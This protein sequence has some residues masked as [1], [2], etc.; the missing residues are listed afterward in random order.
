MDCVR[1]LH[2][3]KPHE[4]SKNFILALTCKHSCIS[5]R[6]ITGPSRLS[7][8]TSLVSWAF[9]SATPHLRSC[10][11]AY[12]WSY[13]CSVLFSTPHLVK[14]GLPGIKQSKLLFP[15]THPSVAAGF[16]AKPSPQRQ[17]LRG[18]AWAL[19]ET[20][21][22]LVRRTISFCLLLDVFDTAG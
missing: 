22:L 7:K 20:Q 12:H 15:P 14:A 19:A 6:Q 18:A 1:S 2:H 4:F 13:L 21:H 8:P 17:E 5:R 16:M 10:I 11:C 9:F 3:F